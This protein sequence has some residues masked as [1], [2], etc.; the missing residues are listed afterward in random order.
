MAKTIKLCEGHIGG[1]GLLKIMTPKAQYR[2]TPI[3]KL[4]VIKVEKTDCIQCKANQKG[5][6]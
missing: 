6:R 1:F 5:G 2:G 4:T 3:K